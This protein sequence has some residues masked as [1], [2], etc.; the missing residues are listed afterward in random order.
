MPREEAPDL[1]ATHLQSSG[2][3]RRTVQPKASHASYKHIGFRLPNLSSGK[4]VGPSFLSQLPGHIQSP[5]S[6]SLFV[7]L[8]PFALLPWG[9]RPRM[10]SCLS[11]SAQPPYVSH[12]LAEG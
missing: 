3:L 4:P 5:S 6:G 7:N 10:P 9:P 8:G 12:C 11:L 1:P 2:P